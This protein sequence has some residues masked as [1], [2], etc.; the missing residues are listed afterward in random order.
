MA[1][2]YPNSLKIDPRFCF[3]FAENMKYH[4]TARNV[5]ATHRPTSAGPPKNIKT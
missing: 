3:V 4:D 5:I 1:A 2:D